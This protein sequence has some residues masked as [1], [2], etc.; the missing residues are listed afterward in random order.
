MW[1]VH[2]LAPKLRFTAPAWEAG[3]PLQPQWV[4]LSSIRLHVARIKAGWSEVWNRAVLTAVQQTVVNLV[5]FLELL[6]CVR[7]LV[8]GWESRQDIRVLFPHFCLA[9]LLWQ[10][11]KFSFLGKLWLIGNQT[12]TRGGSGTHWVHFSLSQGQV[13]AHLQRQRISS[14]HCWAG[15]GVTDIQEGTLAEVRSWVMEIKD[16]NGQTA[17]PSSWFSIPKEQALSSSCLIQCS[18]PVL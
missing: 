11:R 3:Q 12:Q 13:L 6:E 16:D 9:L 4:D 10:E 1:A 18:D 5:Y 2:T 8:L 14:G 17:F 7:P 15:D